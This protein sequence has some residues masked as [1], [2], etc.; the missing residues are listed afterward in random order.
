MAEIQRVL[1]GYVQST[2]LPEPIT[3][4]EPFRLMERCGHLRPYRR[5]VILP[6][7]LPTVVGRGVPVHRPEQPSTVHGKVDPQPYPRPVSQLARPLLGRAVTLAA[8]LWTLPLI[9]TTAH[10]WLAPE[11]KS[12]VSPVGHRTVK[13]RRLPRLGGRVAHPP[14]ILPWSSIRAIVL[15][16]PARDHVVQHLRSKERFH[17]L[18]VALRT[19]PPAPFRRLAPVVAHP[20]R[21]GPVKRLQR[22]RPLEEMTRPSFLLRAKFPRHT[23]VVSLPPVVAPS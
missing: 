22:P 13:E 7:L 5:T 15:L 10:P 9:T 19:V 1:M 17:W 20:R 11:K 8:I 3:A 18:A 12:L 16:R 21:L 14:P 2:C 6:P 4:E 23:I